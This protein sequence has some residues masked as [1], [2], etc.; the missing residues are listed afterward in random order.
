[1][2]ASNQLSL[3]VSI[4]PLASLTLGKAMDDHGMLLQPPTQRTACQGCSHA[5]HG[6]MLNAGL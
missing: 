6:Q 3:A 1:M 5:R 2:P 4:L